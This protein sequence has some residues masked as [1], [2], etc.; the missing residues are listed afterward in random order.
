MLKLYV[1]NLHYT[2]LWL[3]QLGFYTFVVVE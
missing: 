1:I 3:C 2:Q